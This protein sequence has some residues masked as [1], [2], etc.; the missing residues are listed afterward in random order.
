MT[1]EEIAA[2][3]P[4]Y[5]FLLE[6]N[7][8]NPN[9]IYYRLFKYNPLKPDELLSPVGAVFGN[10]DFMG[11]TTFHK[12]GVNVDVRGQGFFVEQ[13]LYDSSRW[14]MDP[15]KDED[16]GYHY[17][18]NDPYTYVVYKVIGTPHGRK[19][20]D[21]H[22]DAFSDF[23]MADGYII[24]EMQIMGDPVREWKSKSYED[25]PQ[26]YIDWWKKYKPELFQK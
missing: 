23:G 1:D 22:P 6:H 2:I 20:F 12:E 24:D 26:E 21:E 4:S 13:N 8:G 18:K 5:A 15:R 9:L 10:E 19:W 16:G 3:D 17:R 14:V 11:T 7:K 25:N